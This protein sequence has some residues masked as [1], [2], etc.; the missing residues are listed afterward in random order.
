MNDKE[1]PQKP[2]N[3]SERPTDGGSTFI[4]LNDETPGTNTT[5]KD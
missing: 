1:K 3:E 5:N 4:T 2:T